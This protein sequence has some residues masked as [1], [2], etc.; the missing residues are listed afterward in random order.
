[1]LQLYPCNTVTPSLS[2]L[3]PSVLLH[4][5]Q[6][7]TTKTKSLTITTFRNI[8]MAWKPG[9]ADITENSQATTNILKSNK[10]Y[11]MYVYNIYRYYVYRHINK[12]W[13]SKQSNVAPEAFKAMTWRLK[14]QTK[15]KPGSIAAINIR[16]DGDVRHK[17]HSDNISS[18][19]QKSLTLPMG[20]SSDNNARCLSIRP[21]ID[22]NRWPRQQNITA[23]SETRVHDSDPLSET[24]IE[25]E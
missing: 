7:S 3:T 19:L 23:M 17:W 14:W 13:D 4:H 1:M 21:C 5:D 18:K 2:P 12:P 24:G 15:H 16:V 9:R 6:V 11:R 10:M 22:R 20:M 25:D 8:M